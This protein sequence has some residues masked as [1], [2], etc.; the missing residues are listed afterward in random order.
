[1]QAY[2]GPERP[3]VKLAALDRWSRHGV[4]AGLDPGSAS[5]QAVPLPRYR[6]QTVI[7]RIDGLETGWARRI[8]LL[9]GR[10][11]ALVE[12]QR[13]PDALS[14]RLGAC[15]PDYRSRGLAITFTARAG[16]LYRIRA[17]R[18]RGRNWVWVEEVT[19]DAQ[20]GGVIAGE[21][22]SFNPASGPGLR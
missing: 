21:R 7:Y 16:R 2:E 10:H 6:H 17:E 13:R 12:Y 14:C 15:V 19:E 3:E 1:M 8:Y 20:S 11:T 18:K 9:P 5:V 22:P 4:F